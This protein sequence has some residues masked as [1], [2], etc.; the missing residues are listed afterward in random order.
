VGGLEFVAALVGSLAWP[1]LV[2][3]IV[4]MLKKPI[5]DLLSS[6]KRLESFE[7]G[8]A[9]VK[10]KYALDEAQAEIEKAQAERPAL[11]APQPTASPPTEA[12]PALYEVSPPAAVLERF[13]RLEQSLRLALREHGDVNDDRRRVQS[14]RH[15]I[16]R[17]VDLGI[18]RAEEG[19]AFDELASIRN[20]VA[21]GEAEEITVGAA[22]RFTEIANDL[23]AAIAAW[24]EQNRRE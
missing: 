10:I 9:G 18:L 1:V 7:A 5:K 23:L 6:D 2:L 24:R 16:R 12:G 3:V 4:L 14:V 17:A 19:R 21:H 13:A 8:P 22:E 11:P 20:Y 15:L